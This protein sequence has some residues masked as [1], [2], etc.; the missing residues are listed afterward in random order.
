MGEESQSALW[1]EAMH[2]CIVI[3]VWCLATSSAL[4]LEC[5]PRRGMTKSLP[6]FHIM[7]RMQKDK[8]SGVPWPLAAT[9]GNAIYRN[10]G[11]HLMRFLSI[12]LLF[13]D[14]QNGHS[15]RTGH[16]GPQCLAQPGTTAC[17]APPR[18]STPAPAQGLSRP[19]ESAWMPRALPSCTRVSVVCGTN[20]HPYCS[21]LYL[22][23]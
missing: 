1:N 12:V 15:C 16:N 18:P 6:I 19:C 10:H 20:T 11:V 5:Q 17:R 21:I 4:P 3:I 23:I 7:G 22:S 13:L 8:K 2:K 14:H 9:D